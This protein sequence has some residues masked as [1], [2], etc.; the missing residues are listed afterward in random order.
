MTLFL[1]FWSFFKIGAFSF[2]GGNAMIDPIQ[3][4]I[5]S[6]GWMTASEFGDIVAISQITPGPLAVNIA[7]YVGYKT[8]GIPGSILATLGVSLPSFILIVL[9]AHFFI[10]FKEN[11]LVQSVLTTIKPITIAMIGSAVIVMAKTSIIKSAFNAEKLVG[12]LTGK[13]NDPSSILQIDIPAL[14]IFS[15]ILIAL[16]KFKIHPIFAI[17]SSAF[18]GILFIEV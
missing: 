11:H 13:L 16:W 9:I 2:G 10:Q 5:E 18:L 14:V 12:I 3:K 8:E 6:L 7:T 1:L 17:V 4:D 15:V